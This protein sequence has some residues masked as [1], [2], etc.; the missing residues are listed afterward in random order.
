MA[1]NYF[2]FKE[3]TVQQD[4][5]AMRVS[6]DA[7]IFGAHVANRIA[8]AHPTIN[9]VLDIGTGTGLLSL[10]VAQKSAA[11]IKGIEIDK[12]AFEQSNENFAGSI[13]Q[14]RLSVIHTDAVSF[15][16]EYA[17]DAIISNPPFYAGDLQ[18][19]DSKKNAAKHDTTLNLKTLLSSI[20]RTLSATGFFSLLLPTRRVEYFIDIA[21]NKGYWLR[22]KLSIRHSAAH[23]FHR[24]ILYFSRQYD[25]PAFHELDIKN[26]AGDYS[27]AFTSLLK[28][29]YL[30]L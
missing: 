19:E 15:V 24:C 28:D 14:D 6:T 25:E 27:P 1:N 23:P 13:W 3:F 21:K 18:S 12:D 4:R 17:Y 30:F 8:S 11:T 22:T 7:C 26:V 2:Q 29:Y 16:A 20:D 9:R 5:C 10:M